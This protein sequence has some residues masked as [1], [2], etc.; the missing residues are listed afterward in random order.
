VGAL[1]LAEEAIAPQDVEPI[2]RVLEAQEAWSDLPVVLLT[3][4][5]QPRSGSDPLYDALG[6]VSVLERAARPAALVRTVLSALR[7]RQR[8]YAARELIRSREQALSRA[9]AASKALRETEERFRAFMDNSPARAW[10]KDESGRYVYVNGTYE[11]MI[12]L[13]LTQ[14]RGK[15]DF[16]LWPPDTAR[17]FR[18]NDLEVLRG[19][20]PVE[21]TETTHDPGGKARHWLNSK[22]P[23]QDEAG[24]TYVG[25]IGIDITDRV[26]AAA[27]LGRANEELRK[28]DRQ[29]NDFLGMLSHELRNPLAPIRSSVYILQHTDPSSDQARRARSVIDRQT[30]HLTAI[31]DD[32]LDVTRIVRGKILLRRD[33][34]DLRDLVL[35]AADDVRLGI[36]KRGTTLRVALPTGKLW[37]DADATRIT[38]VLGNLLSNA[39]K[40][41]GAGDEIVLTLREVDAAAEISVRDT[42]AGIDPGLLPNLFDAFV[43]GERTLARSEGGLGLGLALVKGLVELH[44]GSVEA[45][46]EGAGKGAVFLLRLPLIGPLVNEPAS[47]AAVREGPRPAT[48]KRRVLVVDDNA[49]AAESLAQMIEIFGH[50]IEIAFDGPSAIEM[51]RARRPD[52][53]LCD[54]GLPGMSGY[55]VAQ[56]LRA[57]HD[58]TIRLIAISG[59]AQPDDIQKAMESGFEAHLAKPADP[60]KIETLLAT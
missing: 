11:R 38:Q 47:D 54:I 60:E 33:R 12:G 8:Q 48:A 14:V 31:V 45:H 1:V 39:A 24:R 17:I 58:G 3:K 16:D 46:S 42:G 6:N 18:E 55:E 43:Q 26:H 10:A 2:R 37:A 30:H 28:A 5:D 40:F 35:R 15:T 44:G 13:R 56:A 23:F 7:V 19:G 32:L 22:F 50:D 41:T 25:G 27:A 4:T 51:A 29:K 9:E 53:V 57:E 34:V 59:Y 52:I 20:K 49:D 21:I 36:E